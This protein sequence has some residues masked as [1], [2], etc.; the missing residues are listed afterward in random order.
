M[1]MTGATADDFLTI[2]PRI[3]VMPVIHGSGDFAIQVREEL[4]ARPYDCVAVPLPPSFQDEVEAA[5][6][7]L[8]ADLRRRPDRCRDGRFRNRIRGRI[9]FRG[10]ARV[11]LRPDRPVSGR[12]R[13]ACGRRAA[14]ASRASSSIWKRR[15]SSPSPGHSPTLTRS[16]ESSTERVCGRAPGRSSA[17][18]PGPEHRSHHLDGGAAARAGT[19]VQIDPAGLLDPRLALDPRS[20]PALQNAAAGGSRS[21]RRS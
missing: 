10:R 3:R 11:Q 5:I 12:D 19:A 8:P 16:S 9:R 15:G 6:E 17:A 14:S 7:E 18:V 4:L 1:N 21:S 2:S 20:L 13:G